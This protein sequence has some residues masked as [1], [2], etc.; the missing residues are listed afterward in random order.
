MRRPEFK[1]R[2]RKADARARTAGFLLAEALVTMAIGAFILVALISAIQMVSRAGERSG[3][4]AREIEGTTRS[5][6]AMSRDLRSAARTR[7][8]GGGGAFVFSGSATGMVLARTGEEGDLR[9]VSLAAQDGGTRRVVRSEATLPPFA[10]SL[11]DVQAG[12]VSE[13]YAGRFTVRFAYARPLDGREVLVDTW[14]LPGDMPSAV[15]VAFLD[16]ATGNL[17]STVRIPLMIDAESGCAAPG[18]GVCSFVE[19]GEADAL[20]LRDRAFG[21][22]ASGDADGWARYAR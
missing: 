6:A 1:G 8:A 7:W 16:P 21:S 10:A 5:L 13:I 20:D 4:L 18:T 3:A 11:S 15:R 9:L 2:A 22:A 17:A 14:D 12:P 19:N